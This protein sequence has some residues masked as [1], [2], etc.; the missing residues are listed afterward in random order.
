MSHEESFPKFTYELIT[1]HENIPVRPSKR[2]LERFVEIYIHPIC[3]AHLKLDREGLH[4]RLKFSTIR[5]R[6]L[7][8]ITFRN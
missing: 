7:K 2:T 8:L 4:G 5:A 1:H 3:G 6:N